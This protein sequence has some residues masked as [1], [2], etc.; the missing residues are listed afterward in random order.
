[1]K[2]EIPNWN[3]G[4]ETTR[5]HVTYAVKVEGVVQGVGFRPFVYRLANHYRLKGTVANTSSGVAIHVEGPFQVVQEFCRQLSDK[6]PPLA[7]ITRISANPVEI[8]GFDR[9]TIQKS[10]RGHEKSVLVSPDASLC[11][12]CLRE[13]FDPNDRRYLYPFINCT[14]CGPRF[15]IIYDVPYDRPNTTMKSFTMCSKCRA[16][17]DDPNDRRFHAQPN[18]CARC[19]PQLTLYDA[20]RRIV[21]TT[22]PITKAVDLIRE[23]FV[24][25]IKGLGGFHLCVDAEN[26]KAVTRLRE[27]KRRNDK[28]F[29][30][31]SYDVGR[32]RTFA[33]VTPEE[34]LLLESIQRPIVI[35]EKG[36]PNSISKKVSPGNRYFGV[37]LPYTPLH[38]LILRHKFT[39]LVMTS[40]NISDEP[41]AAENG[42]AF[43]NLGNVA[44]YFLVH[45]RDIHARSDD[46]ILRHALGEVRFLRRSRGFVPGPVFLKE[47]GPQ[48]LACGGQQKN[49]VCLT[50]ENQAFLSQ[51]IG[52]LENLPTYRFFQ[53]TI[54]HLKKILDI[55]PEIIAHDLHPD[56][57]S[58]RY[59]KEQG[60]GRK[61]GIQHHHAH[62]ASCMAEN[63]LEGP[64]I[65]LSFDGTGYGL[66][67]HIWGGEVLVAEATHFQR[68]AYL[69]YVPMPGGSAAIKEPWRM[70]A[71]YLY[72]TFGEDFWELGVPLLNQV[73]KKKI[74]IITE[75][76]SKGINSPRTSSMGRLFDGIAAI[77]GLRY[78]VSYE[79]QAAM[80]L[81]SHSTEV[82]DKIYGYEWV[83]EGETYKILLQPL[84]RGIVKDVQNRVSLSRIG[85]K[86]HQWL[87]FLFSDLCEIVRKDTGLNRVAL[88]GG[89]FQNMILFSGLSKAL[90]KKGFEVYTHRLVPSNDG[91][92]S[93]GQAHIARAA[94]R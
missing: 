15:T 64:V 47:K 68:V 90:E 72:G 69:S 67:G 80:E 57:L 71:S 91:G 3:N 51:H 52:D 37:M 40:G 78:H 42:E 9:F 83:S 48:V 8:K 7:R 79:G 25:A 74:Q 54:Q 84:I 49:T 6:S 76:I 24:L 36:E 39:A 35:L 20:G 38:Y 18:A 53:S 4:G 46:S 92:L 81:E 30:L 50:K 88:S 10:N 63:M 27:K 56:Y 82:S 55:Q 16:E 29:A 60:Q 13:L 22:D 65:G 59:A 11:D 89:A 19:G 94:S 70:A 5:G 1:M 12:D 2:L 61:I 58:T 77:L 66:D 34:E 87:I 31:M 21:P 23:G 86:F 62:I 85:G 43:E 44:D 41:I 75:M 14:N 26:H 17:Y 45:N 33:H 73:E 93:L 28:P 32:I